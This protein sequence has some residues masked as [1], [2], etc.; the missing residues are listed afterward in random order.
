MLIYI[1]NI[2]LGRALKKYGFEAFEVKILDFKFNRD[3]LDAAEDAYILS[4]NSISNGYN[5]KRG[6]HKMGIYCEESRKRMSEAQKG[7]IVTQ[8]HRDKISN[9]LRTKGICAGERNPAFGKGDQRTEEQKKNHL[10]SVSKLRKF[11][12]VK[13]G[14]IIESYIVKFA[15]DMNLSKCSLTKYRKCRGWVILEDSHE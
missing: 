8:E 15:K 6:G 7:R 10:L 9:T 4:Y 14:E 12:N 13:T 2:V 3:S 1:K 5:C 11:K